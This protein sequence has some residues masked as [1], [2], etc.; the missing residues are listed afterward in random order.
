MV[1]INWKDKPDDHDY[2]AA[3]S[4]LSLIYHRD[5]VKELITSLKSVPIIWFHAKDILR[6][7]SVNLLGKDNVHVH[8]DRKKIK[9]GAQLSPILLIRNPK[10]GR[11]VI[12]DG[13]HRLC[14][15]Y[16]EDEDA[17]IPCKI[18]S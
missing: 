5:E 7:S 4:Y 2:P 8:R 13:Y 16:S 6:A 15:V 17:V 1:K 9:D 12:A 14:A 10:L 11:V 3:E 18:T